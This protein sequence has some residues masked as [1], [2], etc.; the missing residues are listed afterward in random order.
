MK[1]A[2]EKIRLYYP[3]VHACNTCFFVA[4][5]RVTRFCNLELLIPEGGGEVAQGFIATP[6]YPKFYL[7]HSECRWTIRA[8]HNQRVQLTLLD[9]SL[10]S[11]YLLRSKLFENRPQKRPFLLR[12]GG[13]KIG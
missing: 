2:I 9:V 8:P 7:G 4:D 13:D 11:K 12:A 6:G 10:S 1:K 5:R 3:D